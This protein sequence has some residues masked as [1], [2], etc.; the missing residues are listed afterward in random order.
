M[1]Q[2]IML[3]WS[4]SL[5][6]LLAASFLKNLL[7]EKGITAIERLMGLVLTLI[8]VQMFLSGISTFVFKTIHS[9][10]P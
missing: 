6:V 1:I 7:G 5:L 3:A 2:A 9:S 4:A 8:A 10:A